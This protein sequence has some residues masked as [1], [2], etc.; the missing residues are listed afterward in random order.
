MS[1]NTFGC[2]ETP[3]SRAKQGSIGRPREHPEAD[4]QR[5]AHRHPVRRVVA[6][7]DVG[8]LQFRNA[9]VT[10]GYWNA[11][12]IT[13][14]ALEGGWL[15]TGDAGYVDADGDVVLV[16]RYKEMIRRRGENVAPREVEDAL[17]GPTPA[18]EA[19]R[20]SAFLVAVRGGRGR[21]RRA[22]ARAR[23][24]RSGAAG[25]V[26]DAARAV[27]GAAAGALP[28]RVPA[29]ADDAR[30]ERTARAEIAPL[31]VRRR[32]MRRAARGAR[33]AS[34]RWRSCARPR[35]KDG[36]VD[37]CGG[38]PRRQAAARHRAAAGAPRPAAARQPH[39][40]AR[41]ADRARARGLR[42][43]R[44][45]R[46]GI[47]GVARRARRARDHGCARDGRRAGRAHA[48]AA[49]DER[50]AGPRAAR[51]REKDADER[52]RATSTA[53]WSPTPTST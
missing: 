23:R 15:R 51:A 17:A 10:P 28:R 26:R 3:T 19:R 20:S 18:L 46:R 44:A 35:M 33:R 27:Q 5:P 6:E 43:L 11:P 53:T 12:E 21:V 41:S 36:I 8:E 2:I 24:R 32:A 31:L 16:G 42:H 14:A 13:G 47:G 50:G 45:E 34:R 9:A 48:R 39:A 4:A 38:D 40:V 49:R 29:H 25:V 52:P 30:R 22:R 1:E 7:R 37:R